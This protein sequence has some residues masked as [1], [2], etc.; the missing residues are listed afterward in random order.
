MNVIFHITAGVTIFSLVSK[1]ETKEDKINLLV[2]VFSFVLG[3]ISHGILDYIPHCYP[4]NSKVDVILG[5][6][7]IL[8][9]LYVVKEHV[10]LLIAIILLG[11]ISPDI[12]DL[13]PKILNS[14]FDINLPIFDNIFPWHFYD[15]SGSIYNDDCKVSSLNHLL[16]LVFCTIIIFFNRTNL[17]KVLNKI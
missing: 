4:L 14:I 17:Q 5:L 2:Y 16:T 13:S 12:I 15:Y 9:L 8:I 3:V 1:K 10:K 6:F 7:I 11:C